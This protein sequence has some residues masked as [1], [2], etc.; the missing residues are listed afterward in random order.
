MKTKTFVNSVLGV[1]ALFLA[2]TFMPATFARSN[3]QEQSAPPAAT[4][5]S[6]KSGQSMHGED[7][8]AGL[9]LTED[10]KAQIKKIHEDA[11]A[12]ADTV[13]ANTSLSDADKQA[14]VKE[15][16]HAAKKQVRGVLTPEQREQLR[17]KMRER[18]AERSKTQP[19]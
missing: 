19:S 9:N 14:K 15:I 4:Q 6:Q 1:G 10:Q 18:R 13:K 5:P 17:A 3:T 16:H 2:G 11:K 8:F 12:K 7:R